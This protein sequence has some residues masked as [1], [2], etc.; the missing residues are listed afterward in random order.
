MNSP[1][2][3]VPELNACLQQEPKFAWLYLLRGFALSLIAARD[4]HE[5]AESLQYR[6][7]EAD[8][9]TALDL[10]RDRPEDE[11]HYVLLV[12]R[13]LMWLQRRDLGRAA[14]D[15][16]EA[17][18]RNPNGF[19]AFTA[20]ANIEEDRKRPQEAVG[21]WS[22]A[23]QANPRWAPLYRGRADVY[24]K[25]RELTPAQRASALGDLE[26]AIKWVA[27]GD[28][29]VARDHTNRARLLHHEGRDQDAL[30]AC[31]AA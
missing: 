4:R 11:L 25:S 10:L 30:D 6:A 7:A 13:G 16:R 23:I 15:L 28:P 9:A 3:T 20:L 21:Y 27:P 14:A 2:E 12:N 31:A 17:V 1:K 18:G 22:Q 24:L 19:Q 29:V 8:Y 26:Q 5:A